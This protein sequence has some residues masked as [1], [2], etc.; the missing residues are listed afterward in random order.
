MPST[1]ILKNVSSLTVGAAS[2]LTSVLEIT[3]DDATGFLKDGSDN[4]TTYTF[5]QKRANECRG[6]IRFRDPVQ[7]AAAENQTNIVITATLAAAAG[8]PKTL[9]IAAASTSQ[10]GGR[11]AWDNLQEFTVNF[12]GG[13]LT[14][15]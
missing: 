8:D 7:A 13:R 4:D 10:V 11:G 1:N 5:T 9:T 2:G 6:S 14:V 15:S 12:E 3:Y